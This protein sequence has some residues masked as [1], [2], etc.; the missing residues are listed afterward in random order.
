MF[1]QQRYSTIRSVAVDRSLKFYVEKRERYDWAITF[2]NIVICT[3]T[4]KEGLMQGIQSVFQQM[5]QSQMFYRTQRKWRSLSLV[6]DVE[7]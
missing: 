7:M 4:H 6:A 1:L 3:W 5:K 2:P